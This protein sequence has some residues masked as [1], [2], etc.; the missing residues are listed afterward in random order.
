M[1]VPD[2]E[3]YP[4]VITELTTPEPGANRST[5]EPKFEKLARW[6]AK[7]SIAPKVM[8]DQA[9]GTT[10]HSIFNIVTVVAL[11]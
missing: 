4:P 2:Q 7:L 3:A 8:A 5:T 1:L 6:S 10:H 11:V 9:V